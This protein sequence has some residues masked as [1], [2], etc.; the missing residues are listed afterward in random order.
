[1]NFCSSFV[2]SNLWHFIKKISNKHGGGSVMIGAATRQDSLPESA[3]GNAK[4]L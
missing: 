3:E 1:M 4:M 2:S